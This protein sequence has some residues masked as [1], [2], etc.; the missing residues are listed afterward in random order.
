MVFKTAVSSLQVPL[1]NSYRVLTSSHI[2]WGE[3]VFK[4]AVSSLQVSPNSK[5]RLSSIEENRVSKTAFSSLQV[6]LL[7]SY[8]V[9][10]S[11]H[12]RWGERVFKTAV[13]S[14]QVPSPNSKRR[15]P[16]VEV[17]AS[18]KLQSRRYRYLFE[19]LPCFNVVSFPLR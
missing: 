1:P 18:L 7:N 11:S 2:R 5:H 14:L 13:S 12:I 16:S 17:K 15:F 4:T 6:P 10:T 19:F 8:H 3:R 9:L